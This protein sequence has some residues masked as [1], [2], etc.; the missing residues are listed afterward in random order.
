MWDT[1]LPSPAKR[2]AMLAFVEKAIWSVSNSFGIKE[3]DEYAA[4]ALPDGLPPE[5]EKRDTDALRAHGFDIEAL[6]RERQ[7][8]MAHDRLSQA[9]I[10]EW[11]DP[12]IIPEADREAFVKD[13][14]LLRGLVEGV[15]VPVP[16]GF[17]PSGEVPKFRKKYILAE[18]AVTALLHEFYVKGLCLLVDLESAK[19][20]GAIHLGNFFSWALKSGKKCGRQCGDTKSFNTKGCKLRCEERWGRIVFPTILDFVE[21]I[22]DMADKYGWDGFELWKHDLANAHTLLFFHPAC[23]RLLAFPLIGGLVM[24]YLA[25][26]FGWCGMSIAFQVV[27]RVLCSILRARL[28]LAVLLIYADDVLGA[29]PCALVDQHLDQVEEVSKGLLGSK[30]INK[31]KR[32][33]TKDQGNTGRVLTALGWDISLKGQTIAPA[34]KTLLKAFGYFFS[35]DLS[36]GFATVKEFQ[37]L[38]SFAQLFSLVFPELR[39]VMGDLYEPLRGRVFAHGSIRVAIPASTATAIRIWR[40]TLILYF[41]PRGFT[42]PLES[43]RVRPASWTLEFDGSLEGCGVRMGRLRDDG[44]LALEWSASIAVP[45]DIRGRP[46]FQNTMELMSVAVGLLLAVRRGVRDSCFALDGDSVTAL[47]WATEGKYRVGPSRATVVVIIEACRRY[48]L[49]IARESHWRNS[50]DNWR[51]DRLSRCRVPV[52]GS[53]ELGFELGDTF[54]RAP[55]RDGIQELFPLLSLIDPRIGADTEADVAALWRRVRE[56]MDGWGR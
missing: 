11:C 10:D 15:Q 16:E 9:R 17:E 23:V 40:A 7:Q 47:T 21:L 39:I 46:E 44:E 27:S 37:T 20:I 25:G 42:R 32:Q 26:I 3:S 38:A 48:G 56:W 18:K 13:V 34:Q 31:D 30:A 53:R 33:S 12:S 14:L 2:A 49:S 22:L 35:F 5:V 45:F 43:L 36:A 55:L 52:G 6:A 51:C 54:Y 8:A 19:R 24:L 29:S 1:G 4:E 41:A 50:E 28:V